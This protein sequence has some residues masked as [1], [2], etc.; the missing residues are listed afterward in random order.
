MHFRHAR[1]PDRNAS[2]RSQVTSIKYQVS[3]IKYQILA[4]LPSTFFF[5][6]SYTANESLVSIE[7]ANTNLLLDT[8]YLILDT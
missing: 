5:I 7:C 2:I 6:L 3:S 4:I 8:C 1:A